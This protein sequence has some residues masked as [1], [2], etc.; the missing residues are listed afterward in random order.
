MRCT[1]PS[2]VSTKRWRWWAGCRAGAWP[3]PSHLS[4]S[5]SAGAS[6]SLSSTSPCCRA[7]FSWA[8]PTTPTGTSPC[9]SAQRADPQRARRRR[10]GAGAGRRPR[11]VQESARSALPRPPSDSE[12]AHSADRA[13]DRP[14][15]DT[16][17]VT[18]A[19]PADPAKRSTQA[20]WAVLGA[21]VFMTGLGLVLLFLLTLATR[22]RALY[23]QNF[24]W[25]ASLNVAVA[26]LLVA[27]HRLVGCALGAAFSP[28]QVRQPFAAQA[29]RH[30]WLGRGVAGGADLH[31]VLPVCVAIDRKLVRRAGGVGAG[32]R[33][34]PGAHRARYLERRPER[35]NPAGGRR[36]GAFARSTTVLTLERLREQLAAS[37]MVL[38]SGVGPGAGQCRRFAFQLFARATEHSAVAQRAGQQGCGR[39]I[40]GSGGSG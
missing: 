40:E 15:S 31:R 12:A 39:S 4:D 36:A 14:P 23:E 34:Q 30:H 10:V 1:K 13:R 6:G 5:R 21:L 16:Q 3:M 2:T 28:A 17:P 37:D 22:N 26:A 24:V 8:W 27:G 29:G 19:A 33:S 18:A 7:R 11:G 32:R 38:W 20:R 25:L 9:A 35:Q